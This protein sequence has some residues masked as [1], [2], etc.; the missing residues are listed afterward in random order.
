MDNIEIISSNDC[1]G[2]ESCVQICPLG[3]IEMRENEEGFYFPVVNSN[4]VLCGKCL[5]VCPA[6]K[7]L[8]LKPVGDICFA[9]ILKDSKTLKNS[10]SGGA[11]PGIV[12]VLGEDL[13]ICGAHYRDNL[14]VEHV[15]CPTS[16]IR[17]L[18]GSKYVQSRINDSFIKIRNYLN[19]DCRVLFTG[20]PCQV[21]A[22]KLFLGKEYLNLYCVE[23]ICH[24]VSSPGLFIQYL[25]ELGNKQKSKV[26]SFNFRN[27][28]SIKGG[29]HDFVTRIE[30]ANGKIK[31]TKYDPFVRSFLR[32]LLLRKCCYNCKYR[33]FN[34]NADIVI[35]DFWGIENIRKISNSTKR[36]VSLIIP[37]TDVGKDICAKLSTCMFLVEEK[38]ENAISYNKQFLYPTHCPENRKV[39]FD[40]YLLNK[41]NIIDILI[42]VSGK[43]SYLKRLLSYIYHIIR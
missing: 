34:R 16:K 36:G 21:A 9:G 22:L 30:Y 4:C 13:I 15:C 11:F 14:S 24:G 20:T 7:C 25:E 39:I 37:V 1:V 33:S 27:K 38:L 3:A 5:D 2:C 31:Y 26:V 18:Q 8:K 43:V 42:S 29:W 32:N 19:N 6:Y 17:I 41:R 35:A 40:N 28:N 10:A 12:K 23:I